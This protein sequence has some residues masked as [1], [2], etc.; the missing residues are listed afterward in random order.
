MARENDE[1]KKV[2]GSNMIDTDYSPNRV[3]FDPNKHISPMDSNVLATN[4]VG[5]DLIRVVDMTRAGTEAADLVGHR[6]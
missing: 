5:R 4:I 6:I 1:A 3:D 2:R